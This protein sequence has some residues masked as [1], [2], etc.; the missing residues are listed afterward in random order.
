SLHCSMWVYIMKDS[1]RGVYGIFFV[2]LAFLITCLKT[3]CEPYMKLPAD[4]KVNV[5]KFHGQHEE[6]CK[7]GSVSKPEIKENDIRKNKGLTGKSGIKSSCKHNKQHVEQLE[8]PR[9]RAKKGN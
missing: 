4:C 3:V 2:G 7:D 8:R 9:K 6:T 1:S 5:K